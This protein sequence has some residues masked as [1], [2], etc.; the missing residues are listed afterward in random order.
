ERVGEGYSAADDGGEAGC[1]D[2]GAAGE[3]GF[4]LKKSAGAAACAVDAGGDGEDGVFDCGGGA[5]RWRC[6]GEGGG[7]SGVR[8]IFGAGHARG[9][10]AGDAEAGGGFGV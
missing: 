4:Q 8:A 2:G 3:D 9:C 7:D 1:E 6:E 10:A 5:G